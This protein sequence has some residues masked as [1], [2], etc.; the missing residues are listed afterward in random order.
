MGP[1]MRKLCLLGD[2]DSD[3]QYPSSI[4]RCPLID[5]PL[6]PKQDCC[7]CVEKYSKSLKTS[8]PAWF[9]L[10]VLWTFRWN[11]FESWKVSIHLQ[12]ENLIAFKSK[13]QHSTIVRDKQSAVSLFKS[14][15]LS[16]PSQQDLE[17]HF[18]DQ[19]FLQVLRLCT[20]RFTNT[21]YTT[22]HL[23]NQSTKPGE[24]FVTSASASALSVVVLSVSVQVLPFR[25]E[26]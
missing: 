23:R 21:F 10:T 11:H 26:K 13:D 8:R 18:A 2:R 19:L 6:H 7:L 15:P 9:L 5:C 3:P 24:G 12:P 14:G 16:L 20:H 17:I 4:H 25:S 22:L 1:L